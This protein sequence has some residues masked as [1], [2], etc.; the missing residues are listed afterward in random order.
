MMKLSAILGSVAVVIVFTLGEIMRVTMEAFLK[1]SGESL[2]PF[3][4]CF[5]AC[6]AEF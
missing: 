1:D 6:F 4:I 2:S 5:S 3:Y